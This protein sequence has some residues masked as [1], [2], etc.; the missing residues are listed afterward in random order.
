MNHFKPSIEHSYAKYS[1]LPPEME[2]ADDTDFITESI[3]EKEYL[4]N[5][6]KETLAEHHLK[7]NDDKTEETIIRREKNKNI[8][9]GRNVRKLGSLLGDFEDAKRRIQ[10]S[11]AAMSSV[12]KLWLKR[13]IGIKNKLKIYKT[14]VKP[15]L[16]YNCGTWGLTKK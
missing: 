1:S 5:I 7:V 4:K 11:Y 13:N 6:I 16:I 2:Y 12:N 9:N 14:L 15:V 10:L 8:E 3:E